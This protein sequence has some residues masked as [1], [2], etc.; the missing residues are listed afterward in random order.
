VSCY[1]ALTLTRSEAPTLNLSVLIP[2]FNERDSI[3]E[4][5]HRV[6]SVPIQKEIVVVNDCSIDGTGEILDKME[7]EGLRVIHHGRNQGK[8]AAIRTA[9]KAATGDVA[10]IQ[11]ADLEYDP[12]DYVKLLQPILDGQAK[13][14][15]GVRKLDG[16]KFLFRNGN[17]M[18]SLVTSLLYGARVGDMETCY[19]LIPTTL[20]RDLNIRCNRFDMEPE[21][22]AKLLRRGY[23][24]HEV[25][26]SYKPR[27][28]KKLSAWR[29]GMPALLTLLRLRFR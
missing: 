18:L 8:G 2:V 28:E 25:P 21:I 4:L 27:G 11:D 10:I 20:F 7:I 26:I 24:I 17:R 29:D 14:V 16:Q 13:V 1:N 15:Y 6:D 12:E 3:E 9:L 23:R 19:K 22:T 5:L